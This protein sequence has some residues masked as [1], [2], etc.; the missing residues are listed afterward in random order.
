MAEEN[1][2]DKRVSRGFLLGQLRAALRPARIEVAEVR[3]ILRVASLMGYAPVA[4]YN[5]AVAGRPDEYDKPPSLVALL[6]RDVPKT[7]Q[8]DLTLGEVRK[9]RKPNTKD[10][11]N[12]STSSGREKKAGKKT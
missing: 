11:S 9:G 6:P 12:K 2:G 3:R 1:L 5:E 8:L 7:K 4:L 10:L